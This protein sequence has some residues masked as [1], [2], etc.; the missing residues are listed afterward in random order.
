MLTINNPAILYVLTIKLIPYGASNPP[1]LIV[2]GSNGC[3]P[4]ALETYS[5]L[6]SKF[7]VL[8]IDVLSQ[9]NKSAETRLRHS[10]RLGNFSLVSETAGSP[11]QSPA[12]APPRAAPDQFS[13][14]FPSS[15]R[16]ASI[17]YG[18]TPSGT[19]NF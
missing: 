1:I 16:T 12:T 8:A 19:E 18:T 13:T 17:R 6:S 3:A 4:I 7:Q 10:P 9:P 11:R 14:R 5:G 2:H 15:Y